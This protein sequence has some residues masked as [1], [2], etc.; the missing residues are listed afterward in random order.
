MT[1]AQSLPSP[2]P[3]PTGE[4]SGAF[5]LEPVRALRA[6]RRL[7]RDKED[8]QQ[9]FEI[10][11]A[12]AGRSMPRGYARLI[13]T[14]EGA[15]QATIAAE[16][17]QRL[18]DFGW[19]ESLPS[20]SVGAAYLAFVR[21]RDLSAQGLAQESLKVADAHFDA[22][23]PIAWYARRLRDI[24]DIWHVLTGYGADALGEACIVAFS[25][26][27]TRS[28]GFAVIAGGAALEFERQRMG[29]PYA[30]AIWE[31]AGL[32]GRACWLPPLDYEPL[33]AAPLA[34]ARLRLRIRR[35]EVYETIPAHLRNGALG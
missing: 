33:L 30:R 25:F 17:S 22:E 28:F 9:V 24:H 11:R 29:Q 16:L 21:A 10:M 35:P 18:V 26:P 2:P 27:Q 12:M 8:T 20:G 14:P 19:L 13:A 32:G 5:A 31:A 4:L 3:T 34:E 1:L 23:G 7:V 6:F 15:R